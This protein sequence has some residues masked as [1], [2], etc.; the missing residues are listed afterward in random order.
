[1]KEFTK[2]R[3]FRLIYNTKLGIDHCLVAYKVDEDTIIIEKGCVEGALF[4]LKDIKVGI[5]IST[6]VGFGYSLLVDVLS[7]HFIMSTTILYLI[8]TYC[9]CITY[10]S[11]LVGNYGGQ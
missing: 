2:N 10:C 5:F 7:A 8:G 3:Q 9:P 11:Y 4:L 1:M 6:L